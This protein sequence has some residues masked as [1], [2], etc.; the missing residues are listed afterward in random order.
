M[1]ITVER[2]WKK[3]TYTV[4]RMYVDG[5]FFCNT[6]EDKDRGLS[7]DMSVEE[8]KKI[9]VYSQTAIP[10]GEYNVTTVYWNKHK[11]YFPAVNG[12]KGFAGILI[13]GGVNEEHT[14]GCILIGENKIKGK[15]LNSHPYVRKL[16]TMVRE[17]KKIDERVTLNIK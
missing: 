5:E 4:G 1:E 8:I 14:L 3:D 13:H 17:A 7:D 16:T 15:L 6:L 2:L 9:K 10:T 12:V 11:D